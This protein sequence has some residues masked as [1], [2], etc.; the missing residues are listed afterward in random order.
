MVEIDRSLPLATGLSYAAGLD[1][2]SR[3]GTATNL[4]ASVPSS[5]CGVG[6]EFVP[7]STPILSVTSGVLNVNTGTVAMWMR[8]NVASNHGA[9]TQWFDS[10][11]A[12]HAFFVNAG[13]GIQ[14][15]NDGIT[16]SF[17]SGSLWDTG[18]DM[19]CVVRYDKATST[20]ELWINGLNVTRTSQ[21]GTWGSTALGTNVYIGSRFSASD[22]WNG[23]IY[24]TWIWTRMLADH[25]M[26]NLYNPSTRW[27]LYRPMT[28]RV[29][30]VVVS[31]GGGGGGS[32]RIY[33][34]IVG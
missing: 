9:F 3:Y 24:T 28:R 17:N 23:A 30:S 29:F 1:Y 32:R 15:Y 10:D 19:L 6:A 16:S 22:A 7:A 33:A 27:S 8:P 25:E 18:K 4:V 2:A 13:V 21:S 31:G 26:W 14:L 11:S 20:Q 12:R 34:G 5:V